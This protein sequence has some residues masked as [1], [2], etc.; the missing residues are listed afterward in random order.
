V[1]GV[2]SGVTQRDAAA[3]LLPSMGG[4]KVAT[5]AM[6]KNYRIPKLPSATCPVT[7]VASTVDI[8]VPGP[9]TSSASIAVLSEEERRAALAADFIPLARGDDGSPNRAASFSPR[10]GRR[11]SSGSG[12]DQASVHVRKKGVVCKFMLFVLF[13]AL[14]SR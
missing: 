3:L 9:S 7:P 11:E 12:S 10:G 1:S 4:V 6:L 13:F 14:T 2:A 5:V 8:A